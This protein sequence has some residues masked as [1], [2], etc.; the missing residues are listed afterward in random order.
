M[1]HDEG[2]PLAKIAATAGYSREFIRQLLHGEAPA[3]KPTRGTSRA[4]SLGGE[5]ASTEPARW[6]WEWASSGRDPLRQRDRA[7][8]DRE[9]AA[10]RAGSSPTISSKRLSPT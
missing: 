8:T 1:A 6:R 9:H 2:I 4:A 7:G 3:T 5:S 10:L